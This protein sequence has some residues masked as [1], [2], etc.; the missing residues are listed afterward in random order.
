MRGKTISKGRLCISKYQKRKNGLKV[1]LCLLAEPTRCFSLSL[2]K[3]I[4]KTIFSRE[5]CKRLNILLSSY[6]SY[7]A[8]FSNLKFEN[9]P[10]YYRPPLLLLGPIYHLVSKVF[11]I[12]QDILQTT[13][14][15]EFHNGLNILRYCRHCLASNIAI[16][17][18][19]GLQPALELVWTFTIS[20][21]N[22]TNS[23]LSRRFWWGSFLQFFP[24]S[25]LWWGWFSQS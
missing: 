3:N 15:R 6:Q 24:I 7:I 25:Q 22:L 11:W 13:V 17:P 14:S 16:S 18:L 9:I 20:I 1:A 4:L 5:S 10:Q 8:V 19:S 23:P 21:F 2:T 12:L